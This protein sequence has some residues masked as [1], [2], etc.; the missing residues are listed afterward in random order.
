MHATVRSGSG[1]S[2]GP[3]TQIT[4]WKT[5]NFSAP[6]RQCSDNHRETSLAY[7]FESLGLA[8][9]A[10]LS[11]ITGLLHWPWPVDPDL[12]TISKFFIGLGAASVSVLVVPN[13]E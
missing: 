13:A 1:T 3:D 8:R 12:S 5:D 11:M 7:Y 6:L 10:K 4:S 9:R 2:Q